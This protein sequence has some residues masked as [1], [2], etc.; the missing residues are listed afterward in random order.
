VPLPG[1][2]HFLA[3]DGVANSVIGKMHMPPPRM[4]HLLSEGEWSN[5][6]G[7]RQH[8]G[9]DIPLPNKPKRSR[10]DRI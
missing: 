2:G 10:N 8:T 9:I 5:L 6:R 4:V 7:T 3:L 1:T